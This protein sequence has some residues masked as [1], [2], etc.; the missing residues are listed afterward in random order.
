[1]RV[2]DLETGE[3]YRSKSYSEINNILSL[4]NGHVIFS[5][6]NRTLNIWD[7]DKDEIIACFTGESAIGPIAAIND[8]TIIVAGEISG[9]VHFLSLEFPH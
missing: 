7:L 8:G 2:W 1:V 6:W 9:L 5:S 3:I 4:S